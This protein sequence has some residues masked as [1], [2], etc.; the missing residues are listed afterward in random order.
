MALVQLIG[1]G[2]TIDSPHVGSTG[3][4]CDESDT[5]WLDGKPSKLSAML[6]G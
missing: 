2:E 5:L 6:D 3:V 1:N 4:H